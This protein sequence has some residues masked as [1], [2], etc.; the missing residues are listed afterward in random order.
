MTP[1]VKLVFGA[2]Y[3]KTRLIEFAAALAHARRRGLERGSLAAFLAETSGGLK[4]VV[5]EERRLRRAEMG[6]Q[7]ADQT[8]RE[9]LAGKLRRLPMLALQ[10]IGGEG[11]EFAVLLIRRLPEGRLCWLGEVSEDL[12]LIDR[13]A[14][15]L[16]L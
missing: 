3:D 2:E 15:R 1:V 16:L 7:D 5:R 4:G 10:D 13:T 8:R 11:C 12:G 9:K 6:R 14:R